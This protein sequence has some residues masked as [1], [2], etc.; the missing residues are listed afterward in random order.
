MVKEAG[1]STSSVQGMTI[2]LCCPFLVKPLGL[3]MIIVLNFP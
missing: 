1:L 2:W 3:K